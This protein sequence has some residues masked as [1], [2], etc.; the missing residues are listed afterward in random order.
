MNEISILS[1]LEH[2]NIIAYFNHF[3]DKNTLLIEL[4]YCNGKNEDNTVTIHLEDSI[5]ISLN[6]AL[7]WQNAEHPF[8]VTGG[9]LYD[10][11]IQQKGKLFTE[12]VRAQHS[13][14]FISYKTDYDKFTF[15]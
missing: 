5:K 13:R 3:M 6:T 14:L 11:I 10:K 15:T 1:I 4:E 2:N 8:F 9:N 7:L 12:E